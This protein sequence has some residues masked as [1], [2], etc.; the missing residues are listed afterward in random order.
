MQEHAVEE[1]LPVI[2][3]R[4]ITKRYGALTALQGVDLA[5]NPGEV[6]GLVGDNGAGKSTLVKILSGALAPTAG[7]LYIEGSRTHLHSPL[8]ARR[9]GI[10]TV[11]QDLALAPDL[12]VTENLF[13]GRE[14]H[15]LFC[16]CR[17]DAADR[18]VEAGIGR[19]HVPPV[20]H[21]DARAR[22]DDRDVV[23]DRVQTLG[24]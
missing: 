1:P 10:E 8:D 15:H 11:Y 17:R 16:R 4:Q 21:A 19:G 13:I 24:K 14:R 9:E 2:E 20:R 7:E 12:S 5:I 23:A 18:I 22:V 3:A 6:V